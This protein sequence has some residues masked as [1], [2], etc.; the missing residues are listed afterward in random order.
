MAKLSEYKRKRDFAVTAEPGAAKGKGTKGKS[1]TGGGMFVVQ[2]HD[3]SRLHY[4]FRLATE[5]VLASWA[6]PKGFPLQRGE[7]LHD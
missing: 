6:V 4:D 5:G 7:V 1:A 2:K 3:A